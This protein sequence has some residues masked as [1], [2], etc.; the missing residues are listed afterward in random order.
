MLANQQFHSGLKTHPK[1]LT[2]DMIGH[3]RQHWT[4]LD[5]IGHIGQHWTRL[6][7]IGRIGRTLKE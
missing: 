7:T 6:D 1:K 4:S 3:T 2:L 5:T